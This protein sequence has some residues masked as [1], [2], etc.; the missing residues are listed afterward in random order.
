MDAGCPLVIRSADS[1]FT[2]ANFIRAQLYAAMSTLMLGMGILSNEHVAIAR[3]T[4]HGG[5]FKTPGVGQRYMAAACGAPVACMATAAEGGPYGMALL[6]AYSGYTD[7]SLEVFL[8]KEVFQSVAASTIAPD[9]RDAEG[10][11]EHS[12]RFTSCL[13]VEKAAV[14]AMKQ[15]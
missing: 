9:E 2:L 1:R 13:S 12:S 3:L 14:T 4:G 15:E 8:A 5:L 10:F 7:M 6:A 11:K